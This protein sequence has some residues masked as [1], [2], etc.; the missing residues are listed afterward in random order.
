MYVLQPLPFAWATHPANVDV[1]MYPLAASL[2]FAG[3]PITSLL[4]GTDSAISSSDVFG[5]WELDF[6]IRLEQVVYSEDPSAR[7]VGMIISVSDIGH[8][9]GVYTHGCRI[10]HCTGV[11]LFSIRKTKVEIQRSKKHTQSIRSPTF[12]WTLR[13]P[14]P[15][16]MVLP[17]ENL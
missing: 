15:P 14:P 8:Y 11:R 1:D 7:T 12:S 13:Y 5:H 9:E 3:F 2:L 6:V 4:L 10:A 17:G 16:H